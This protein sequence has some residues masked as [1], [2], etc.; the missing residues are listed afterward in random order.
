MNTQ[1][2][3]MGTGADGGRP[4]AEQIELFLTE[5]VARMTGLPADRIDVS[6]PIASFGFDSVHAIELVVVTEEWLGVPLPDNLPWTHPTIEMIAKELGSGEPPSVA[7][8]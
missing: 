1:D 4:T 8:A 5:R 7:S 3:S 2:P 6:A